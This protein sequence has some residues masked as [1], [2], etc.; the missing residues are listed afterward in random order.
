LPTSESWQAPAFMKWG[1]W[2]ANPGA[3]LHCA[4]L[5]YWQQQYGAELVAMTKD[6]LEFRVARPP[7]D[8]LAAL[9]LARA[10]FLY[11]GDRISQGEGSL[12]NLAAKLLNADAWYFWWD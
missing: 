9:R 2:N 8:R 10:H 5:R 1:G 7:C 4:A 3:D 6:E 12:E 11:C